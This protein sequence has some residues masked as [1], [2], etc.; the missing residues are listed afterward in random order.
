MKVL[1]G[2][3]R[4]PTQKE[5]IARQFAQKIAMPEQ[6][7]RLVAAVRIVPTLATTLAHMDALMNTYPVLRRK[8]DLYWKTPEGAN[9]V[10]PTLTYKSSAGRTALNEYLAFHN[11][12][13][14]VHLE[15]SVRR[16]IEE[17]QE[18]EALFTSLRPSGAGEW[19]VVYRSQGDQ[20]SEQDL[21]VSLA[22]R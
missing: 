13:T 4:V 2:E 17:V 5:E 21:L 9:T 3:I 15:F 22:G 20:A 8:V 14:C 16:M 1:K 11:A 10:L 12:I 7:E 19:R 6:A 18:S